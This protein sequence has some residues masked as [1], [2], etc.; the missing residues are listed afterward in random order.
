MD[1]QRAQGDVSRFK[2]VHPSITCDQ[3]DHIVARS[4]I[5]SECDVFNHNEIY[6]LLHCVLSSQEH[7]L[8]AVVK[9]LYSVQQVLVQGEAG[10]TV[11]GSGG[12]LSCLL[13][14]L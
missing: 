3:K 10:L 8:A 7:K 1:D 6:G 2:E 11:S 4:S 13:S 14:V 9:V 12:A 5:A